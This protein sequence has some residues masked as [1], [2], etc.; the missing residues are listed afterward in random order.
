MKK[1]IIGLTIAAS[2]TFSANAAD[3]T[4]TAEE[5]AAGWE[6]LFD[7]KE[8]SQNWRGYKQDDVPTKWEIED[9]TIFFNP[10]NYGTGGDIISRETYGEFEFSLEWKVAPASNSGIFYHVVE[11]DDYKNTYD[12]GPEMQVLDN[13]RHGDAKI[14]Q[15]RAGD[16]Y[17]LMESR[18]ENVKPVGEWNKILIKVK[19]NNLEH[20][21][22]GELVVKTTMWDDNWKALIKNSKFA[23]WPGFGQSKVGHFALQDH[24]DP[25][26]FKNIKIRKLD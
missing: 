11:S 5:K 25:V 14:K 17:D 21:Q 23:T 24:G 19:G 10:N 26:W 8:I 16:L 15:H 1:T 18:V 3:N 22:N 4:L 2:M 7:G 13:D 6:L 9:G 12:T 20:W